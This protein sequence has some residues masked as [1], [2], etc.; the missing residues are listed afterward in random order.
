MMRYRMTIGGMIV[1][2]MT[3]DD[4]VE[5]QRRSAASV[6]LESS[7]GIMCPLAPE[8]MA[9]DVKHI[10]VSQLLNKDGKKRKSA[11]RMTDEDRPSPFET[12]LED[13]RD[14]V[15]LRF[16]DGEF[17]VDLISFKGTVITGFPMNIEQDGDDSSG[18]A[19]FN[20]ALERAA[21]IVEG[22]RELLKV[23]HARL[24]LVSAA[25]RAEKRPGQQEEG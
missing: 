4:V 14:V 10:R 23:G 2:C 24:A 13:L 3:A 22:S 7:T 18:D 9:G 5:L 19:E 20:L 1:E 12:T 16:G 25:I 6:K 21:V 11:L 8:V 15:G 17:F